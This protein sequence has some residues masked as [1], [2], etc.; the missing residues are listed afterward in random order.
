[1][2]SARTF[3]ASI[4]GKRFFDQDLLRVLGQ[5][6]KTRLFFR[7]LNQ[8]SL[9][10][11]KLPREFRGASAS[12]AESDI[13]TIL[14]RTLTKLLGL[15]KKTRYLSENKLESATDGAKLHFFLLGVQ[16]TL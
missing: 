10:G 5:L 16:K 11:A 9:D 4:V 2:E 8:V 15:Q 7:V 6:K 1:V 3:S 12:S 13:S 14:T